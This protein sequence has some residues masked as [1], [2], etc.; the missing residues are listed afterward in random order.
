MLKDHIRRGQLIVL[1]STTYPGTTED[2]VK[3]ILEESGLRAGTDF[4]LAF[5][6]TRRPGQPG[7]FDP[8]HSEGRRRHERDQPRLAV[9]LYSPVV[10]GVIPV[11]STRVA[12]ACKILENTYRAVNIA[13]VNELKVIFDAMDIDVWEVIE[14]AKSKPFGFQPSTPARS[15]RPLHPD[16]PVLPDLDCPQARRLHAFIELAGEINTAMPNYVVRRTAEAL[17]EDGKPLKGAKVCVL[18]VA[19]KKNVDDP[20]ESPAFTIMRCCK[21]R[22]RRSATM[23]PMCRA[24][25]RC[26]TIRFSW[27][28]RN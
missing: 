14:A 12:E 20:R 18:G 23:T 3:P 25:R 11:S 21:R 10:E 28:A 17:N 5:S 15:G 16:R 4:F 7:L 8:E 26:G 6:P 13:L 2:L 22:G 27:T 9:A 24:C 19:Y 1:E